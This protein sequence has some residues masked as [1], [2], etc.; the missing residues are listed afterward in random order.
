MISTNKQTMRCISCYCYSFYAYLYTDRQCC[1]TCQPQT[2]LA[3]TI[4]VLTS[5]FQPS[6]YLFS[7]YIQPFQHVGISQHQQFSHIKGN[8]N[9]VLMH[10]GSVNGYQLLCDAHTVPEQHR[11][12]AAFSIL[13]SIVL[14][15][16]YFYV[17]VTLDSPFSF[18]GCLY[19]L[20]Q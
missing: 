14:F 2:V 1:L 3:P 17:F 15:H 13:L 4:D 6:L 11:G 20:C 19:S 8:N 10:T 12:T 16:L 5:C 9:L 7:H 18:L